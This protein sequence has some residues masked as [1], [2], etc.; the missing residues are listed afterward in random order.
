MQ[1]M[2]PVVYATQENPWGHLDASNSLVIEQEMELLEVLT[3]GA[4][5]TANRYKIY[6]DNSGLQFWAKEESDCCS[7]QLCAPN[8]EIR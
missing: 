5:E 8:H 7:R 2:V 6:T 3:G 4:I 1:Q